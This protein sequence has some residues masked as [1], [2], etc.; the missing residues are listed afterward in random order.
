MSTETTEYKLKELVG[1][2]EANDEEAD[3]DEQKEIDKL[4]EIALT[5]GSGYAALLKAWSLPQDQISE[6][7]ELLIQSAK[8]GYSEAAHSL[9]VRYGDHITSIQQYAFLKLSDFFYEMELS[10]VS[11]TNDEMTV[12]EALYSELKEQLPAFYERGNETLHL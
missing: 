8:S 5:E 1:W 10:E 6:K 11:L 9:A 4:V 12:A 2:N 3:A 7:V